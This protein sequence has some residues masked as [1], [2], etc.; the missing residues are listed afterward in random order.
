MYWQFI[1]GYIILINNS[2]LGTLEFRCII[3]AI[4]GNMETTSIILIATKFKCFKQS[5]EKDKII[6]GYRIK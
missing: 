2:I 3:W 1:Y 6:K 5:L 4:I